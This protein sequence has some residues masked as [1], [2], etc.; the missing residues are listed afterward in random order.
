MS[1]EIYD[2]SIP[3]VINSLHCLD[4]VMAKGAAS[5]RDREINEEVMLGLR[6]APDM[7]PLGRQVMIASDVAKGIAARL[8][9]EA[10]PSYPDTETTFEQLHSR[11]E[12][13]I[14]FCA[15]IERNK[16]TGAHER[17]VVMKLGGNEMKFTGTSYLTG[18]ALPNFYFHVTTAYDILRQAG[19]KLSKADYLRRA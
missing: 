12:K 9:G 5:A 2:V 14:A 3:N 1:F 7:L 11:L 10:N 17:E 13:T 6:L 8:S 18:F 4:A 19:V 16:F 15:G